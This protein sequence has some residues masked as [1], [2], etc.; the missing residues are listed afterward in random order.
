MADD[1][2]YGNLFDRLGTTM[3]S[4]LFQMGAGVMDAGWKGQG[5]GAGIMQGSQA[6]Q[7]AEEANR[8]RLDAERKLQQQQQQDQ[9]LMGLTGPSAPEWVKG[10]PQGVIQSAQAMRDPSLVAPFLDPMKRAEQEAKIE[11]ARAAAAAS[12]ANAGDA[13]AHGDGVI[14]NKRTGE[15]KPL[16]EGVGGAAKA[17]LNVTWGQDAQGNLVPMQ[18]TPSGRMVQSQLPEG[19]SATK[20]ITKVDLGTSWGIMNT[21]TGQVVGTMPKDIVGKESQEEI[22]KAQGKAVADLPRIQGNAERALATIDKIEKHPGKAYGVGV[23][24]VMPGVP[25][26]AQRGFINL[27]DQAKGQTFLE[28]FNSLRGGGAITEAEGAKATQAL[29]RLDRAQSQQDFDAALVDLKDVINTGLARAKT[30]TT[31]GQ[32]QGASAAAPGPLK[33]GNYNWTSQGLQPAG[34]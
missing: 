7:Q 19:V 20:G 6:A 25:G 29:A 16:P 4:P 18:T 11:Q 10:V 13:Y 12:R 15:V 32:P 17:S 3:Q 31:V 30:M 22:G 33:S 24:G 27:V 5:F 8:K 34:R 9:F 28:A 23:M 2:T 14:Y 1:G 26:T 21:M